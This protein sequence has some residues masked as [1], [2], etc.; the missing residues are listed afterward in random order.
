MRENKSFPIQKIA[1]IKKT[2]N[3]KH[4]KN[5]HERAKMK[6]ENLPIQIVSC[7]E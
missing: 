3:E 5:Y 6:N 2:A 7:F 1:K 4:E